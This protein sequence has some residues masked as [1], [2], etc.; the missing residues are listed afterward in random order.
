MAMEKVISSL[1]D[2][3]DGLPRTFFHSA[4]RSRVSMPNRCSES[5]GDATT[6]TADPRKQVYNRSGRKEARGQEQC[7]RASRYLLVIGG[8]LTRGTG[9]GVLHLG[10]MK[11]NQDRLWGVAAR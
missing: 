4:Q 11:G 2:A 10:R 1:M 6:G 5:T 7:W 3:P 8:P 9:H